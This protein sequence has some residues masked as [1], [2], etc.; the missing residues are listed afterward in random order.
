MTRKTR[1]ILILIGF[2]VFLI[3][4][5][6]IVLYVRGISY[7]FTTNNFIHTGI[8]ALNAEPK[9]LEIFL[10]NRLKRRGAGDLKFILPGEYNITL[11]KPGYQTWSKRL[12]LQA[13][14]VTWVSPTNA[15]IYLLVNAPK[16]QTL[17]DKV[18]DF[19]SKDSLLVFLTSDQRLIASDGNPLKESH[20]HS[21]PKP[22]DKILSGDGGKNFILT[23]T[24][25][26]ISP[27]ILIFNLETGNFADLTGLF[28][29]LPKF[30]FSANG[31]LFAL[32]GS[33]LYQ[34]NIGNKTK[35]PVL[36]SVKTFYFQD[37]SLYFV[38]QKGSLLTL[39]VSQAPFNQ[40]QLLLN[41]L[42]SFTEAALFVTFEK[43]IFFSADGSL[44][45]T[46]STMEKVADNISQLDFDSFNSSLAIFHSGE[47]DYLD[48][49]GQNLNFVTRSG[50]E[51]KNL[52]IKNNI[53]FA[54]YL[55][56]TGLSAIELDRRDNQNQ[57]QLYQGN[58][59]QKF[60]MDSSGKN[61]LLLDNGE[62]KS[63][64]IR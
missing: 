22:A 35:Q 12:S 24:S 53:G 48:P 4:A 45:K 14:Q 55:N 43:Q 15:K 60:T 57:Y 63:L 33:T 6:L 16:A 52:V 17:A 44:Y 36:E 28:P 26:S 29:T 2:V 58:N 25:Q 59:I 56:N 20:A 61:V 5:P 31:D 8:F 30:Q 1:Y 50:L 9:D 54:F 40:P 39:F 21:L 19:Y 64:I 3:L 18:V 37:N 27:T 47:F 7:N 34:I 42:P 23:N 49:F 41:N 32:S 46:N 13:G 62:L 38:S 10:N 51:L 11:T